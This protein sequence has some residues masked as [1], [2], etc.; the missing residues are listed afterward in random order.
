MI[1]IVITTL[2]MSLLVTLFFC[3][4]RFVPDGYHVMSSS[5]SHTNVLSTLSVRSIVP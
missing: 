3:C 1:G 5:T 4:R 2:S